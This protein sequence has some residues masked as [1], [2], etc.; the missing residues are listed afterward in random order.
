MHVKQYTVI[1][2]KIPADEREEMRRLKIKPSKLVRA[3]IRIRLK[4]ERLRRLKLIRNTMNEIFKKLPAE[5][6]TASIREDRDSR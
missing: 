5:R 6:V 3:A 4:Q 2:V 1:S